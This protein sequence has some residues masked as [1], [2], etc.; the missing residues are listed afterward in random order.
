MTYV[1]PIRVGL[2]IVGTILF[3]ISILGVR[4]E[5]ST[6]P[7]PSKSIVQVQVWSLNVDFL[8]EPVQRGSGVF[9][10]LPTNSGKR[11]FIITNAHV[12]TLP[13]DIRETR[14]ESEPIIFVCS[15]RV[16]ERI[17]R[18]HTAAAIVSIDHDQ[19]LALLAL[20]NPLNGV[21]LGMDSGISAIDLT[22]GTQPTVGDTI[23]FFGYPSTG[24]ESL[25]LTQGIVSGFLDRGATSL[26][27]SDAQL[28]PGNSGGG[29][30]DAVGNFIGLANAI[31]K[32]PGGALGLAIPADRVAQWTASLGSID[33]DSVRIGA[34]PRGIT[35]AFQD[36]ESLFPE[37][38][39]SATQYAL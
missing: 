35:I 12:V 18:C 31:V 10:E 17:P 13:K 11:P 4:A 20:F 6:L 38:G 1:F 36:A 22:S 24:A 5:T 21:S 8:A 32:G 25:T 26:I 7:D 2:S 23:R 28:N 3:F 33:L 14:V 29:A 37:I 16:G 9:V 27:K 19:D 34:L 15:P 39:F 30:F